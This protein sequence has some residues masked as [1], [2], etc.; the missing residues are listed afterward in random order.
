VLLVPAGEVTPLVLME[1]MA[2]GTPV[3]A[4]R[5][6]SI[7]SVVSDGD[8][9]MLVAPGDAGAIAAA[10]ARIATEPELEARLRRGGR[11]HVEL[12]CDEVCSHERLLTELERLVMRV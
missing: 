6:G 9:G 2:H 7:P 4:A 8:N 3:V 12:H 5:M 1:A 10:I 11:R